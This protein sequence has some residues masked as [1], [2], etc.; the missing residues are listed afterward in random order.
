MRKNRRDNGT[1]V[2]QEVPGED[3]EQANHT[4]EVSTD[5]SEGE[6]A[7]T[8]ILQDSVTEAVQE[9][10]CRTDRTYRANIQGCQR[11]R[12][13]RRD[14]NSPAQCRDHSGGVAVKHRDCGAPYGAFR[15]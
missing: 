2:V 11:A 9:Q 15:G 3:A 14:G 6:S 4:A 13:A 10:G 7:G 5:A 1:E 8:E 12:G